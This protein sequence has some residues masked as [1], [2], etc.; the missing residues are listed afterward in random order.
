MV[1]SVPL[2]NTASACSSTIM[3]VRAT[4]TSRGD[5]RVGPLTTAFDT[6]SSIIL[7]RCMTAKTKAR[8]EWR[9][10]VGVGG[11][12]KKRKDT[13]VANANKEKATEIFL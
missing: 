3:A 10:M 2:R 11:V 8:F 1:A 9:G 7:S 12:R 5:T 13:R 4:G 6:N